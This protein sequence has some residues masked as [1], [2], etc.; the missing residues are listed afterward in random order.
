[1]IISLFDKLITLKGR[2]WDGERSYLA[3]PSI[4]AGLMLTIVRLYLTVCPLK[5]W[6]TCA[7]VAP[8]ACVCTSRTIQTWR[9]VRTVVQI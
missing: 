4:E 9:I 5:P 2:R 8:F 3:L 1:M 7:S 6:G